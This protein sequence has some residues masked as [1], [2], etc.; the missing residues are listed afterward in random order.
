MRALKSNLMAPLLAGGGKN[1]GLEKGT[2]LELRFDRPL[3]LVS[4]LACAPSMGCMPFSPLSFP[5]NVACRTRC[6]SVPKRKDLV[7]WTLSLVAGDLRKTL[8]HWELV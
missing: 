4:D 5:K 6:C 3:V 8:L 2:R 1:L 7:P